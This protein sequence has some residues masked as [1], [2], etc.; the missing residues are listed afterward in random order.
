[1]L[2]R[3]FDLADSRPIDDSVCDARGRFLLSTL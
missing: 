1:L 3:V 2:V